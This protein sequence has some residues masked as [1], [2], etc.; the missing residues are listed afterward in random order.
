MGTTHYRP[1][2]P[3]AAGRCVHAGWA[4][5]G[6]GAGFGFGLQAG[7]LATVLA[8]ASLGPVL[9]RVLVR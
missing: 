5:L 4:I 9:C 2:H 3:C 8:C 6:L 7:G 1:E